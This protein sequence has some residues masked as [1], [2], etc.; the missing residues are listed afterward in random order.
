MRYIDKPNRILEK[1][2]LQEEKERV[3][4]VVMQINNCASCCA[5]VR[6]HAKCNLPFRR[7]FG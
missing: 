5:C 2:I 7:V 6:L 1:K 4:R 3:Q